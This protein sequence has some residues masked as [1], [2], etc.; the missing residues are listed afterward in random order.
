MSLAQLNPRRPTQAGTVGDAARDRLVSIVTHLD[1]DRLES[2]E[3]LLAGILAHQQADTRTLTG[4]EVSALAR[5]GA[6]EHELRAP[7]A[8]PATTR[9]VLA[10]QSLA[11]RSATVTEAAELL[12][13]TPARIR[14]RCAAGTLIA[15]RTSDGWHLP[16]FQFPE[17]R[18]LRGWAT[19]ARAIPRG[20]PVLL[21]ERVLTSPAPA[22]RSGGEE[23][24]PF[25]WLVQGG[26]AAA[27]ARAV[28][29]ALHRLP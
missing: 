22:L 21:A 23:L 12:G 1:G 8:L 2:A 3:E 5:F 6:T 27:A 29:D 9:G 24:A 11:A 14:Q 7:S 16:R 28:D 15:Q 25:D 20:T 19:V 4:A 10:N 13:V 17:D 26:D 18:E